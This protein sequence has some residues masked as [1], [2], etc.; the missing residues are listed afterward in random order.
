VP[1]KKMGAGLYSYFADR[2]MMIREIESKE[3]PRP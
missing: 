2:G 1:K 3:K